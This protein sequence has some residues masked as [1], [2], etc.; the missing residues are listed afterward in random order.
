MAPSPTGNLHIGTSYA[1]MWSYLFARH[2]QGTFILRFEDTDQER[3]TKEFEQN[4]EDGLKWLGFEWD[5]GPFHQMDRLEI[6]KK[7]AQK[8]IDD[9]HAYSCFCTKEELDEE[10]KKQIAEK[11]P[12]V[13]LGKCRNLTPD[14]VKK[15]LEEGKLHAIRLKLP[16]GRGAVE[17]EDLTHGKVSFDSTLIG[18]MVIVRGNG[19]P[20]YNFAVVCDDI[21]MKIT[22]V[23]RGDDHISNTPKQILIFEALGEP[24][25]VFSHFPMILNQDR[26]GKLSKRTGSTSLDEFKKEGYL[27]EAMFNYLILLGWAPKDGRE[28]VSKEEAVTEFELKD[29]SKSAA[30][31]NEEKL[32][33]L[34]GEYIRKMSDEELT[35]RLVEF[36]VDHPAKDQIGQVVPLIKERIKKLSDFVPLTDFLFEKPEYDKQVFV[37]ILEDREVEMVEILKKVEEKLEQLPKPW[38]TEDFERIFRGLAHEL[39]LPDGV[40][41]QLIRVAISGQKV[42]PPLFES[43]MI[44]GEEETR[45]RIRWVMENLR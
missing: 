4:I 5:E 24:L 8:L 23:I 45:N 37:D 10:R 33:W 15:N 11:K 26:I 9:G 32:D 7:Y 38:K 34:N 25:P 2:N 14:Q 36:L 28:I 30:A 42:T 16:Q 29:M 43:I 41:F 22:H 40:I 6:Y 13:Y 35:K 19:V 20:L 3:S 31:W 17:F 1:T 18:D 27:P 44:L 21:E 39:G 12:Q